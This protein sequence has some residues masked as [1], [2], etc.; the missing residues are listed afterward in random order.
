MSNQV[1]GMTPDSKPRGE[2]GAPGPLSPMPG[3]QYGQSGQ[4]VGAAP[5]YPAPVAPPYREPIDF[6]GGQPMGSQNY[7]VS[8]VPYAPPMDGFSLASFILGLTGFNV[9]AVVFG[10]VGISRTTDNMRSGRWMAVVGLILGVVEIVLIILAVLG[11]LAI[12]FSLTLP[13]QQ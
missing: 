6:S 5:N 10:S 8:P 2:A 11:F 1:P 13:D 7:A 4:Y 12:G 9:L 3:P